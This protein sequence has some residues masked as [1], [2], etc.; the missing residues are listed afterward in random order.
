MRTQT[1]RSAD[2]AAPDRDTLT[3]TYRAVRQRTVSL[4]D[5]LSAEDMVAQSM[6]DASPTKWHMG[7]TTWFFETFLLERLT[8]G[9]E[10]FHPQFRVIFNSYYQQIGPQHSRPARGLLTRPPLDEVL[11]YRAHVDQAM[12]DL[13]Q[14][15]EP[16]EDITPF[17]QLG[18][19][20]EEQHQELILTDLLHLLSCNPLRPV[21]RPYRSQS[22]SSPIPLRWLA[23]DGGVFEIG[24]DG[25]GFA[26][27]D[28][29]PR[30][31]VLL[32]PYKLANRPVTVGDWKE[33]VADGGYARPEFWLSD[34]WALANEQ[35]WRA[36]LYWEEDEDGAW[37][38]MTLSGMQPLDD[39]APVCHVSHFEAD[40]YARWAGKR[41]P[42]E[43]EWEVA[44]ANIS[45]QGNTMG[46]EL[47]RPAA[48][49][50]ENGGLLQMF[51]DVWELTQS[52]FTP[53]PG[54]KPAAGAVG[55]YNGKFMSGQVVL[56]GASC[57][58]ADG[59]SSASYRN[60]FY[61]FQ[62]WQFMGLRLADDA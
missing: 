1:A 42:T 61:P 32:R 17:V 55:E 53:Y 41:L 59:H 9:F 56:R 7:H 50:E 18:L 13:L 11:K 22:A 20:H 3:A 27:D 2:A 52:A 28:E 57:A 43:A 8:P 46:S 23:F 29:G 60:F 36:P 35:A 5:G 47:F 51:G 12:E 16:L 38:S 49:T 24:H 48:A 19:H 58:T 6:S 30:H 34:G 25:D 14:S 26:F 44:A 39:G 62:R 10:P 33:F 45:T 54:F 15:F 37:S 31:E 40:A 21:Y 4:G